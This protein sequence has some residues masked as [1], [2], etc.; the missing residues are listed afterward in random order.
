MRS[1]L[2]PGVFQGVVMDFMN[3]VIDSFERALFLNDNSKTFD[4]FQSIE[5]EVQKSVGKADHFY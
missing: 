3:C 4:L 1:S 5:Q 2:N